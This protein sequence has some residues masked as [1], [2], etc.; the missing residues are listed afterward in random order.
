MILKVKG[1]PTIQVDTLEEYV[2]VAAAEVT[3]ITCVA[4]VSGSLGGKYFHL[5]SAN[6]T[7]VYTVWF[8]VGSGNTAPDIPYTTK[9]EVAISAND[10]ASNVSSALQTAINALSDFSAVVPSG[11]PTKTAVTNASNGSAKDAHDPNGTTL[12]VLTNGTGFTFNVTTQGI[13]DPTIPS[14]LIF[15]KI[16]GRIPDHTAV[17]RGNEF[18]EFPFKTNTITLITELHNILEVIED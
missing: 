18:K 13:T 10:S 2:P 7:T 15:Y 4:D 9:V 5:Y 16:T 12:D 11:E 3:E 17:Q 6:N 14:S 1:Y 8:N